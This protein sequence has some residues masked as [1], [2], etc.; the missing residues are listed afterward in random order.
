MKRHLLVTVSEDVSALYGVRFVASFIDHKDLTEITLLYVAQAA[1]GATCSVSTASDSSLSDSQCARGQA[2][3]DAAR[4]RLVDKG[5]DRGGVRTLLVNK[6]FGTVKDIAREAKA[7]LYDAVVFGRRGYTLFESTFSTS[8]SREIMD[9]RINFPIWICR[10]P[11]EDRKGVL[12]CVDE[13]E[14]SMR[15][16][17]HVGFILDKEIQHNITLFHASSGNNAETEAVLT[18]AENQLKANGIEEHR[19]RRLI[20]PSS[21]VANAIMDELNKGRYAVV[22]VGRGGSE[23]RG[24]LDKWLMGSVSIKLMESLEK[25]VLWVSK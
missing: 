13:S 24:I 15:I 19:I 16:A 14:P 1:E 5:F 22:A 8:V 25:A 17:D 12:V 6:R 11:E 3:L 18:N 7:G 4:Q 10:M 21:R 20:V 2:A 9:H 23:S